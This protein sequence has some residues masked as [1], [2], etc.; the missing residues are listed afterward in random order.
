[1]TDETGRSNP[2][3]EVAYAQYIDRWKARFTTWGGWLQRLGV[4]IVVAT[5]T[6]IT[7]VAL[8]AFVAAVAAAAFGGV[9]GQEKWIA[10]L[11]L[12]LFV[13]AALG[14]LGE[15]FRYVGRRL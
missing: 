15:F 7:L 6:V 5:A 1:M 2:F 13:G 4:G 9:D 10:R 3:A 12:V 8:G 11:M 14:G